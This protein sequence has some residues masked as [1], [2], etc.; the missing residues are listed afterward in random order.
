M[1]KLTQQEY[2]KQ[3]KKEKNENHYR[4]LHIW[5]SLPSKFQLQQRILIFFN[6][7]FLNKDASKIS[8]NKHHHWIKLKILIFLDKI[9]ISH[10]REIKWTSPC[11]FEL[12]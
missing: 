5:I 10:L 9:C 4:I 2:L 6:K 3:N 7:F 11:I 1:D 8:E 12:V